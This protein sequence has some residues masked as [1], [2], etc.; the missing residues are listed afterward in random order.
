M[1]YRQKNDSPA[2][3]SNGERRE[4]SEGV[5]LV[6]FM[7]AAQEMRSKNCAG[8]RGLLLRG[9]SCCVAALPVPRVTSAWR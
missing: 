3:F 6:H 7:M 4:G 2:S 1:I 9:S 8:S 5:G